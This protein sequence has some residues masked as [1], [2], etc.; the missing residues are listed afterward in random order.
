MAKWLDAALD[1]IPR[2]LE[3]QMRQSAQP[4]CVIAI[5]HGGRVVFEQAFGHADAVTG[6]KLTPRHR[7]RVASH[8]KS[9]TAAGILK[10]R[11]RG[12]LQLDT[13]V[14]RIVGGLHERVASATVAQLLSH[15]GGLFRDGVDGGFWL[16]RRAFP[17]AAQLRGDLALPPAIEAN[18]RF[19][20][21]NHGFALAGRV[22][23]ETTGEG[24]AAWIKREIVDAVGLAETLPDVPLPTRTPF[25][26]GH[27]GQWPVGRRLVFP[28][29]QSTQAF[30]PAG[31]FVSTAADLVH[32]FAHLSPAAKKSVLSPA[33]RHEMTRRHWR[34]QHCSRGRW[35]GLGTTSGDLGDW[36]WFGHSGS[37]PGY[38]TRTAVVAEHDLVVSVL[39]NASDGLAGSWLDGAL[40]ILRCFVEHGAPAEPLAD[41]RGR[42]WTQEGASDLVA[43]GNTVFVAAPTLLNP[44]LDA[45]ELTVTGR[46]QGWIV[47]AGS[48]NSH[49]EPARLE[50]DKKGAVEAVW[51]GGE[52]LVPEAVLTAEMTERHGG[53][54]GGVGDRN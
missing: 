36:A 26:C 37:F 24:Y 11:E 1:Y 49:G 13:P 28:G 52:K 41:W 7:F 18:T 6:A 35:Y 29:D 17:D 44:L 40:H 25:A 8:S 53:I 16:S 34:E 46:D 20:Y 42:W 19:K 15:T 39:T 45:S 9:F 10:L 23:E 43:A 47:A 22:I 51:L 14:G 38:R 32:F 48:F 30:A 5:G 2:W 50:R 54:C 21:S 4:G 27:T 12:K 33:S 3:F 31:G